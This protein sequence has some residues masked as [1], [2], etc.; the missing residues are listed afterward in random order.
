MPLLKARTGFGVELK[1]LKDNC[2]IFHHSP[3]I[4]QSIGYSPI[5]L[6]IS[7]NK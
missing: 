6:F 3:F 5:L 4:K 1:E 2:V 7:F